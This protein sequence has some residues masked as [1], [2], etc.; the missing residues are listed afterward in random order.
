[1]TIDEKI[2]ELEEKLE[3][4]KK[5]NEELKKEKQNAF[6]RWRAEVG[7]EYFYLDSTGDIVLAKE[8]K[9]LADCIRYDR[10]NYYKDKS[11]ARIVSENRLTY[12]QLKDIALRLNKGR[13]IDWKN[14]MQAKYYN[15]FNYNSEG[16]KSGSDYR[17]KNLNEIYCLDEDFLDIALEVIDEE[18]LK[19]LLEW[20]I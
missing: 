3:E 6:K 1:M 5:E 19:Q 8:T 10:G 11:V 18:K 14:N 16:F 9:C 15:Y 4:I 7:E 12:Q 20:G 13:E 17:A 2:K